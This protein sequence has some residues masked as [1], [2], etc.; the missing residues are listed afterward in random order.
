MRKWAKQHIEKKYVELFLD[1]VD[2]SFAYGKKKTLHKT[3]DEWSKIFG[4]SRSTFERHIKWLKENGFIKVNTWK[5]Y[6]P[7]GG[8]RPNSYSPCF[9]KGYA[10]I[11]LNDENDKSKSN[12]IDLKN[13]NIDKMF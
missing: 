6:V 3:I 10:K 11:L 4:V 13:K 12:E 1:I 8:S 9:P 5:E 7:G 2:E